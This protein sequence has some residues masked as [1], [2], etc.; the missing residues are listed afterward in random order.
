MLFYVASGHS[1]R[2]LIFKIYF[3]GWEINIKHLMGYNTWKKG[4]MYFLAKKSRIT[5]EIYID[6][7]L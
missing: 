1:N 5:S 3:Q 4:P 6:Q 2:V 7:V